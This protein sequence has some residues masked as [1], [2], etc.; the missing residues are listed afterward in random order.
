MDKTQIIIEIGRIEDL[1]E[2][3]ETVNKIKDKHLCNIDVNIIIKVL[4]CLTI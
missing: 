3:V 1:E 4:S 2:T